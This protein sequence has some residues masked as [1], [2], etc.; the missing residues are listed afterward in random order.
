MTAG[1]IPVGVTGKSLQTEENT[2]DGRVVHAEDVALVTPNGIAI[3]TSNRLPVDAALKD[4]AG[5]ALTSTL[6]A[7]KQSLDVNVTSAISVTINAEKSEDAAAASGATGNF[8]LGVRNDT[9]ADTTSAN[10][11]YSQISVTSRG[12]AIV[13][14]PY[15]GDAAM[16]TAIQPVIIGGRASTATPTAVSA[17]GDAVGL[18]LN[19]NGA[20]RIDPTGTTTQPVSGTVAIT[21]A[22]NGTVDSAAGTTNFLVGARAS[23]GVPTAVDTDGDDQLFWMNRSGALRNDP[24]GSNMMVPSA[25]STAANPDFRAST[26][27]WSGVTVTTNGGVDPAPN[28]S[29]VSD[30]VTGKTVLSVNSTVTNATGAEIAAQTDSSYVIAGQTVKLSAR[31]FTSG[32]PRYFYTIIT[33]F[34]SAST[35]VGTAT[36]ANTLTNPGTNKIVVVNGE[37]LAPATAVRFT[38]QVA[39]KLPTGNSAQSWFY[40]NEYRQ[41]AES[42]L[43]VTLS[44][45]VNEPHDY[46]SLGYTG[47]NL[48]SVLFKSGGSGGTLVATLTLAYTGSQLDSVTRT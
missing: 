30:T 12:N 1:F 9:A 25:V 20:V 18:W 37:G 6:N 46:I 5:T 4:G 8:V 26:A 22:A 34:D 43:P 3:S 2:I 41:W 42:R 13:E 10:G 28:V 45:L 7:G 40:I 32:A 23:I 35:T 39:C 47:S 44:K 29:F 38:V 15:A 36:S 17:D 33:F 11:D 48:T 14:G 31:V 19:R 27:W 21:N 16:G 24:L